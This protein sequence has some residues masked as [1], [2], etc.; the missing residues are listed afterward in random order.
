MFD[1][2]LCTEE[3]EISWAVSLTNGLQ[4][5]ETFEMLA[6]HLD[7][8][9]STRT[10]FDMSTLICHF[11]EVANLGRSLAALGKVFSQELL[12]AVA[13]SG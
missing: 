7:L 12:F 5:L 4:D 10:R 3:N 9:Y 11:L 8:K 13:K 1:P 2:E 6:P